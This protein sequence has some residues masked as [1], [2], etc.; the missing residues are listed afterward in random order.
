MT[1]IA[2]VYVVTGAIGLAYHF[3]KFKAH[4]PFQHDFVWVELL[5]LL[6]I[7]CGVYMLRGHNWVRWLALAWIAF[8]VILSV[9][10][11]LSERAIHSLFC[12]VLA[13]LLFRPAAT[14]YLGWQEIGDIAQAARMGLR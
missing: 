2:C 6:A 13:Y 14:R 8:Q 11:T 9:F 3:T 7:V 12:V 4:H 5:R 10:H 1:I